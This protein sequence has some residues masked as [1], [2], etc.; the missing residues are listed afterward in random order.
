M[1][2]FRSNIERMSGYVPGEQPRDPDVIKLNTNENPY[3][4]SPAVLKAIRAAAGKDLRK[5]P[6][7]VAA[8]LREKIA[9]VYDTKPER[10]LVGNGSDDL[11]TMI[12]RAL[13]GPRAKVAFPTPTYSLYPTLCEIENAKPVAV[14]FPP[15]FSL[16][17]KLAKV[18]AAVT[19]VANP[20]S[21]TGTLIPRKELGRLARKLDGVLVVDEAYV[22]FADEN[23]LSLVKRHKNVIVLRTFSKSFSLCGVRL[24]FAVAREEIVTGLMK[25]KDSYNVNA[26]AQAAGV[27]ALEDI[28]FM[29]ANAAKIKKTR[30]RLAAA[31]E[32]LGWFVYPSQSNFIF[33]LVRPP[34]DAEEVYLALKSRR[35]LV[36]YLNNGLRITVGTDKEIAT[37]L[38]NLRQI[39]APEADSCDRE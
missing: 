26:L 37:L 11:L 16:P 14:P 10:V 7:P 15:D 1:S 30:A 32:K 5:Y 20:N 25:V 22:D 28:A 19:F 29:R 2:Y 24:G 27:A 8:R 3:P 9:E 31:L 38:Q 18:N 33:A 17:E 23:C 36:R 35:I 39:C 34:H 13:A 12:L 21:P 4:P 6:D